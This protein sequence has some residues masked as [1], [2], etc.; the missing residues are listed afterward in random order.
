MRVVRGWRGMSHTLPQV[1]GMCGQHRNVWGRGWGSVVRAAT[2][3]AVGT[4]AH[5]Q[6]RPETQPISLAVA[7]S[8]SPA[9]LP[10]TPGFLGSSPATEDKQLVKYSSESN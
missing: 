7:T 2:G 6:V 5:T 1:C 10:N 4:V 9:R 8:P 3:W